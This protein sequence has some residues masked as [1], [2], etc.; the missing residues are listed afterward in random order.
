MY[1][2]DTCKYWFEGDLCNAKAIEVLGNMQKNV[3]LP[4]SLL[5]N[6]TAS[7]QKMKKYNRPEKRAKNLNNSIP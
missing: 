2:V 5:S 7:P 1:I 3:R 6:T 4:I